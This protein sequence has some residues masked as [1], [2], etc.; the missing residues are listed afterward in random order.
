MDTTAKEIIFD[1]QGV[2]SFCH[3]AQKS[4]EENK[5]AVLPSMKG[6]GK[7]DVLIGLSGGVDSSYALTKIVELGLKPLCFS[8]DNGWNDT[9]ADENIMKLVEGLKVPFYRYKIDYAKF[10]EL[11]GAFMKAGVINIEIPSDHI[12]VATAYE[13]ASKYGIKWI[14]SGGNT[15]TESIMP[16]SWGYNARDL[17]HIKD[18]YKKMIGKKLKG[19]PTMS[20][21]KFNYYRWVKGI[22]TVN[23][24]D[25]FE[26]NRKDAI[27]ELADRFGYVDYGDKHE[28]S[29]F[30]KWFQ[31]YYLFEKWNIDKRKAH[32]SSM[33]NS[34]Q[35]TRKEALDKLQE[36]PIY[37]ELGLE[38][39]VMAY[40]KH[41]HDE[42]KKDEK[43]YNLI[44]KI[45]K[46][47]F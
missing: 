45:V 33:I 24:L 3:Q 20:L 18:I 9:K 36:C 30:T 5:T 4:L 37:P 10:L 6:K 44:R 2:C 28:E 7:Y 38:K 13:M 34:G 1:D 15:A 26:Y 43:L 23:I 42:Y 14:V 41:S 40:P 29:V 8:I 46:C 11:Q 35:M 25:Y 12:I 21:L 31:N 17:V 19:L 47:L 16:P 39:R 27:F 22:K 32:Y